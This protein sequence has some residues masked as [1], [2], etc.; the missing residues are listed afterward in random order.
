MWDA[1]VSR[2]VCFLV[3]LAACSQGRTKS[4]GRTLRW[5]T[6]KE[7][8]QYLTEGMTDMDTFKKEQL[9]PILKERISGTPENAEVRE[10]IKT[11]MKNLGWT[12]EEDSFEEDTPFGRK[13]FVNII[14]TRNPERS[15][16]T[17]VACHFDSKDFRTK[18][19]KK[20]L[21]ATDSAVPC[22]IMLETAKQLDCLLTKGPKADSAGS[23]LTLQY[24][25]FDGEEAFE[26]WTETDSIYGARHLA[27]KWHD[28]S[29][30]SSIREL[31]LLDLIGTTDTQFISH[32]QSTSSLFE[33]LMK[34]E[35]YLRS[36]NMLTSGHTRKI[37]N[38]YG[39]Y[40]GGIEDDHIPFLRKGVEVL[41][42][43]S[44]PFPSV[45][46]KIT[47]D[48]DHLDV[49]LIDNFSRI[50]RAFISNL[51]H[52]SPEKIGCRKK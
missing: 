52:L 23:D 46:H 29:Q 9:T 4:Q 30:L 21:A 6:K 41:H 8:L 11:R 26:E 17:I 33:H 50:F 24:V 43:I 5:V 20:F 49:N 27:K 3:F 34:L 12:V 2:C 28:N 14:A 22:A 37:F 47:D 7:A 39:G 10:H 36:N 35:K 44:T 32:F 51:L 18:E 1:K 19:N 16:R 31:I 25:F 13:K 45:W 38:S 40:S 42:L 48:A 15:Q